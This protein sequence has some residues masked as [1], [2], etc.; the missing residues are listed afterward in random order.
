MGPAAEHSLLNFV[1][2]SYEIP[3]KKN[4]HRKNLDALHPA[5]IMSRM[6]ERLESPVARRRGK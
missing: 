6:V 1:P 2:F 5:A 3:Q 4:N